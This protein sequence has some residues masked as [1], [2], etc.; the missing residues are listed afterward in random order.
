MNWKEH[1]MV[2]EQSLTQAIS[3]QMGSLDIDKTEPSNRLKWGVG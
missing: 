2:F 3:A 1:K